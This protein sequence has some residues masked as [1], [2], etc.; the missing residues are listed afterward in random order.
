MKNDTS[1]AKK[2]LLA[3]IEK[4]YD[5][6]ILSLDILEPLQLISVNIKEISNN[7]GNNKALE[8]LKNKKLE[9]RG[10]RGSSDEKIRR[11]WLGREIVGAGH[12]PLVKPLMK[13]LNIF[14]V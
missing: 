8:I 14:D 12:P 1:K 4:I 7:F 13:T 2:R 5:K 3:E 10:F 9:G 11:M 6:Y